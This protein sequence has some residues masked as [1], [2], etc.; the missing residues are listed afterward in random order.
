MGNKAT[1]FTRTAQTMATMNA[2][3]GSLTHPLV[4]LTLTLTIIHSR[5]TTTAASLESFTLTHLRSAAG[6]CKSVFG[7][8]S[9][10]L[11]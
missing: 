3:P 9:L 10:N 5:P 6:S 7:V 4:P 8:A 2:V 11:K 1:S